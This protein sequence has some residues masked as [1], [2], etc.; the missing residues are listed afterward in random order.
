VSQRKGHKDFLTVVCDIDRGKLL[1]VIDSHKQVDIIQ[2]LMQ[3]PL[4]VRKQV[5]EV[6]VDM[7]GGFPKV[8]AEVFPN[9]QVVFDRFHIMSPI[10]KE[11]NQVRRQEG[12]V[13]KGSKFILLKNRVDLLPEERVKLEE[14]L[15]HSSRLRLG[16]ELKEK[17][18]SIF[19]CHQ[20]V[21]EGKAQFLEWLPIAKLVYTD[22]LAT[23]E[24]HLDGICNYFLNRTTSGVMEGI[25][26]RVKLIKRQGYG[27]VNFDNFRAR[28][29]ACFSDKNNL[30]P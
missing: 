1:E 12:M 25:N 26:N 11:L 16:Y 20:T 14:I 7:W 27:F 13:I 17:F 24:N 2:V 28:L 6:S 18:R 10:N 19:E 15:Q 5:K 8:I 21:E 29:L 30:S 22:V 23:I 4:E 9:A 3:Q